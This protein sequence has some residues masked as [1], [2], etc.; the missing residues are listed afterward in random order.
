MTGSLCVL[1][2]KLCDFA[3]KINQH[4]QTSSKKT[5]ATMDT[6]GS[7]I[8]YRNNCCMDG[9]AKEGDTRVVAAAGIEDINITNNI[10]GHFKIKINF[11]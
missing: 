7:T 4:D 10:C 2:E 5:F 8:A 3:V 1:S 11:R 9:C 6:L